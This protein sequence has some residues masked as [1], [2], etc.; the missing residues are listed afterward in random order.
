MSNLAIHI[1]DAANACKHSYGQDVET[2]IDLAMH[3]ANT[4]ESVS[5]FLTLADEL[6]KPIDPMTGQPKH[7]PQNAVARRKMV[8]ER[9]PAK[10]ID[11]ANQTMLPLSTVY[12]YLNDMD[13]ARCRRSTADPLIW[14]K[15]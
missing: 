13:G 12:K 3:A 11:I 2:L 10:A 1:R 7:T 8:F 14:E 5:A 4:L 6:D 15:M 9:L